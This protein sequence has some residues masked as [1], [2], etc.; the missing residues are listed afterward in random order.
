MHKTKILHISSTKS[1]SPTSNLSNTQTPHKHQ[2]SKSLLSNHSQNLN[3]DTNLELNLENPQPQNNNSDNNQNTQTIIKSRKIKIRADLNT[4]SSSNSTPESS[5]NEIDIDD[6]SDSEYNSISEFS[7]SQ[8]PE[9]QYKIQPIIKVHNFFLKLFIPK[10]NKKIVKDHNDG[11]MKIFIGPKVSKIGI[12]YMIQFIYNKLP[13]FKNLQINELKKI[14]TVSSK[15]NLTCLTDEITRYL[16]NHNIIETSS[17]NY[18]NLQNS[19]L[20]SSNQSNSTGSF[21]HLKDTSHMMGYPTSVLSHSLSSNSHSYLSGNSKEK[22]STK[23]KSSSIRSGNS[24]G[25]KKSSKS[26][27]H[28]QQAN[29]EKPQQRSNTPE[30]V[31]SSVTENTSSKSFNQPPEI[32][33][34]EPT[35]S[36]S[37]NH[38]DSSLSNTVQIKQEIAEEVLVSQKFLIESFKSAESELSITAVKEVPT[39]YSEAQPEVKL[40]KIDPEEI[41]QQIETIAKE[42]KQEAIA[43]ESKLTTQTE[44][45]IQ[46]T[47]ITPEP[48]PPLKPKPKNSSKQ[49]YFFCKKCHQCFEEKRYLQQHI[50]HGKCANE[51]HKKLYPCPKCPKQLTSA[52]NLRNH[53]NISHSQV[54]KFQCDQCSKSFKYK[55]DLDRHKNEHTGTMFGP[56]TFCGKTFNSKG[57]FKKHLASNL[58]SCGAKS[59]QSMEL[60]AK[61]LE[62]INALD[63]E[64]LEKE[65]LEKS[66]PSKNSNPEETTLSVVDYIDEGG[67]TTLE[68]I[69]KLKRN[70]IAPEEPASDSK[71]SKKSTELVETAEGKDVFDQHLID[72]NL[73][74]NEFQPETKEII[75]QLLKSQESVESND[76]L[77]LQNNEA[78]NVMTSQKATYQPTSSNHE[79]ISKIRSNS[80]PVSAPVSIDLVETTLHTTSSPKASVLHQTSANILNSN[81]ISPSFA[82]NS[83]GARSTQLQLVKPDQLPTIDLNNMLRLQ[84]NQA[85]NNKS[86]N[87]VNRLENLLSLSTNFMTSPPQNTQNLEN[88]IASTSHNTSTQ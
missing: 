54:R 70:S 62:K 2:R 58:K 17:S 19:H 43:V 76:K 83:K 49:K 67:P 20:L 80:L 64:A 44:I 40:E 1:L 9:K 85:T 30:K 66:G 81:P 3:L 50:T 13:Q 7:I 38:K 73:K 61:Q 69:K 74:E 71:K 59:G 56:C 52:R 27:E 86:L 84:V 63:Q 36:S 75:I 24:S 11:L 42:I 33:S 79:N 78:T 25:S 48:P 5:D 10:L 4:N 16:L 46:P 82:T 35:T 65:K 15:Y 88:S 22:I 39:S 26:C 41:P 14:R 31:S 8:N 34:I 18:Q 45:F 37:E 23:N 32:S 72:Y 55:C 87:S 47:A 60:K 57:N 68:S 77:D 21:N 6:S 53:L 51:E 28:Q 29:S 12:R